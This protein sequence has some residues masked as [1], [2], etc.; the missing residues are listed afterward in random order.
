LFNRPLKELVDYLIDGLSTELDRV[1]AIY[2]WI[3]AQQLTELTGRKSSSPPQTAL[4]HLIG[5][6][7]KTYNYETL[8]ATMCR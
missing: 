5:V 2:R 8:V 1:R 3:T 7:N 4:E 6:K